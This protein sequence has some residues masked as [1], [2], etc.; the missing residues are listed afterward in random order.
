MESYGIV[1]NYGMFIDVRSYW[2]LDLY[3]FMMIYGMVIGFSIMQRPIKDGEFQDVGFPT[4]SIM[5]M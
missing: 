5:I 1:A 2:L 3:G 4:D